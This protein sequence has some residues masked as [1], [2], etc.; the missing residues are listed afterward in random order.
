MIFSIRK[1]LFLNY[2]VFKDK[3][4]SIIRES[5]F[6]LRVYSDFA[7]HC[8]ESHKEKAMTCVIPLKI[9][10]IKET[11]ETKMMMNKQ[12]VSANHFYSTSKSIYISFV[13]TR[14]ILLL[15][16]KMNSLAKKVTSYKQFEQEL[17]F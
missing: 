15:P 12:Y 10:S 14:S 9:T 11:R 6:M 7:S 17:K 8:V 3:N 4:Q 5:D 13:N 16:L 1:K 2:L